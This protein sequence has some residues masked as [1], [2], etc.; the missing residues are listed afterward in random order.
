MKLF[1]DWVEKLPLQQQTVLAL[2]LRGP[3]GFAKHHASKFVLWFYRACVLKAAAEGRMLRHHE[4][5]K[6]F[7]SMEACDPLV[8]DKLLLD[9]SE[10]EDELPLHFYTHLMHAAQVL[11]YKH[12]DSLIRERW[13]KFYYQCCDFLHMFP[14]TESNMDKRLSDF[15]REPE[16]VKE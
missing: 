14:E 9:F 2:A 13:G 10:V 12:P 8:W 7:M 3:D 11:H 1:P 5:C 16:D 15:G 6:T 4:Y